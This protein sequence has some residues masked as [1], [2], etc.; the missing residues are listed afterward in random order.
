MKNPYLQ[1]IL[2]LMEKM[3]RIVFL[4]VLA[5]LFLGCS[6]SKS[7]T[8]DSGNLDAELSEKNRGHIPLLTRIRQIPGVV[9]KNGV[10]T[11]AKNT[12]S[13]SPF[14]NGEPLYVLNGQII[15]NSFSRIDEMVDN[16]NVKSVKLLKASEA[17]YYGAQA[18]NG[19]IKI[20][21]Y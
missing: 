12:N 10:P 18:A 16:F 6:A 4:G 13:V 7:N 15:G 9:L 2:N 1:V 21:T 3:K 11:V 19:V 17:G 8:S 5:L 20:T 14:G